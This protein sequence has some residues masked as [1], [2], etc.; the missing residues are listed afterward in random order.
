VRI[1]EGCKDQAQEGTTYSLQESIVDI[2]EFFRAV[3]VLVVYQLDYFIRSKPTAPSLY[4]LPS[5]PFGT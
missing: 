5:D 1:V 2:P 3:E 4:H